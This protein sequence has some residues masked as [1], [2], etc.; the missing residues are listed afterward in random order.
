MI[1][2]GYSAGD[3]KHNG[4]F[5]AFSKNSDLAGIDLPGNAIFFSYGLFS[6]SEKDSTGLNPGKN[7]YSRLPDRRNTLYWNPD[8]ILQHGKEVKFSF[9]TADMKGE[10]DIIVRSL[11]QSGEEIITGRSKFVVE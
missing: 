8:L 7:N 6:T 10:Y 2:K 5:H 9:Y 1:G 3:I 11:S 4:I